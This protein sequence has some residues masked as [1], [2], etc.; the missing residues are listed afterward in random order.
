MYGSGSPAED[1]LRVTWASALSC[2][3]SETE[4]F[5]NYV[6]KFVA[7]YVTEALNSFWGPFKG[8]MYG[9][10][11]Q[12]PQQQIYTAFGTCFRVQRLG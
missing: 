7:A 12:M 3:G 4:L 10:L 9:N 6:S 11:I 1:D 8:T 5:I 2:H